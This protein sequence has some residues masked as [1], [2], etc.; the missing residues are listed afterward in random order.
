LDNVLKVN[1]YLRDISEF[2]AY[3]EV[4]GEYFDG[5]APPARTTVE[6]GFAGDIDFEIDV[7]AYVPK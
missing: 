5:G 7:I 1:A 6:V 4:Y 3:N 2:E